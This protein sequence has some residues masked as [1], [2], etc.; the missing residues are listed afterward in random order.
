MVTIDN[1][2]K[3]LQQKIYNLKANKFFSILKENG[4]CNILSVKSIKKNIKAV[5]MTF[6]NVVV[7]VLYR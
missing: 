1:M 7:V 2:I 3:E 4:I 6:I 5:K